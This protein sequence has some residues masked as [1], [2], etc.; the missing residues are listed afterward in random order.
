[1]TRASAVVGAVLAVVALCT[2]SPPI[3]AATA[4]EDSPEW[5]CRTDGNR[6]CGARNDQ[7]V[8]PGRYW[9]CGAGLCRADQLPAGLCR[10]VW[11][12]RVFPAVAV[13]RVMGGR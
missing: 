7:D 11:N 5:D 1:V 4:P 6:I 13:S 10:A 9:D 2:L 12:E 8:L 3:A